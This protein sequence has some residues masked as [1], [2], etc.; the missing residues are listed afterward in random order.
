MV[1]IIFNNTL[2]MSEN[3]QTIINAINTFLCRYFFCSAAAISFITLLSNFPVWF[4][5]ISPMKRTPPR[6][7]LCGAT[8]SENKTIENDLFGYDTLY[9]IV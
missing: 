8:R 7:F 9:S 2:Y 6:S 1:F 4:L 5:G 3:S